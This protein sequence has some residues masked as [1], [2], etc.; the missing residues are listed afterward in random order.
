M[1]MEDNKNQENLNASLMEKIKSGEVKM[2]PKVYFISKSVGFILIAVLLFLITIFL[3]SFIIFFVR[4]SGLWFLPGFGWPGIRMML[5]QLPWFLIAVC[6]GLV[7]LLEVLISRLGFAYRRPLVY[8]ILVL[9]VLATTIGILVSKTPLHVSAFRAAV[10]N[11]L[12]FAGLLYRSYGAMDTPNFMNGRVAVPS[13][14][15]QKMQVE[16]ADGQTFEVEI[17]TST[18]VMMLKPGPIHRDDMIMIMGERS[19]S[20]IKAFG[21]RALEK[22]EEDF[23]HNRG[24]MNNFF[25]RDTNQKP[26]P[27]VSPQGEEK[28]KE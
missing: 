4:G 27:G 23:F 17:P 19:G 2:K 5:L 18:N 10:E 20:K 26:L 24:Q 15:P 8:S 25:K 22:E 16:T 1:N 9:L 11:K 7:I 28:N 6:A 3:V 12:P 13:D 14:G 21:L